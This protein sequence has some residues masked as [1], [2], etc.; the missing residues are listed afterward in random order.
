MVS[1][2]TR[3]IAGVR[4]ATVLATPGSN[5]DSTILASIEEV[6]HVHWLARHPSPRPNEMARY[7]YPVKDTD[8]LRLML[9]EDEAL[10]RALE[11]TIERETGAWAAAAL[12]LRR[13]RTPRLSEDARAF[14]TALEMMEGTANYVARVAVGQS[15]AQTAAR[16]RKGQ[17]VEGVRWRFYDSGTALCLLLD[18]LAPGWKTRID[19]DTALTLADLL[20]EAVA[21]PGIEAAAFSAS[22]REG[23]ASR[24]SGAVVDSRNASSACA[25]TSSRDLVPASSSRWRMAPTRCA[26]SDSTPSTCWSST[27][28]RWSTPTS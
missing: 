23:F 21:R 16:L 26:F 12:Q 20:G 5:T 1:N 4:T 22:E 25:T 24:A 10:A 6:F 18:C 27:K 8:N 14:E 2:S 11:A 28:A 7:A 15:A 17:P 19:R 3:E 13:T 9:A